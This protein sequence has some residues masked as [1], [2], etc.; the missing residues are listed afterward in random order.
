MC[1][2]SFNHLFFGCRPGIKIKNNE[3]I[4]I[5]GKKLGAIPR[6]YAIVKLSPL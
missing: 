4:P 5:A 2:L 6:K 1:F 3:G